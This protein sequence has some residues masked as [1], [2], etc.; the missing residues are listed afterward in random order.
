MLNPLLT[1]ARTHAS[2]MEEI[3]HDLHRNP[4]LGRQETATPAR[5][6]AELE[7]LGIEAVTMA[8]TGVMGIIRGGKPGKTVCFRADMDALPIQEK[9]ELSYASQVPGVMHA[10]GHDVHVAILLGA[11]KILMSRKEQLQGNVKLFFQPDEE[12]FGG[13][14]RM[15]LDGC[16][17]DPPVDAAFCIHVSNS[18]PAGSVAVRSGAVTA[19]CNTF[20]V[21]FRGKGCH[22]SSPHLGRDV[23][24]AACQA[25][26]ALQ[27]ISSRSVAPTDPVV[28]TVGA[29]HAGTAENILPEEATIKGT[30]RTMSAQTRQKVKEEFCRIVQAA[31]SAMDVEADIQIIDGYPA[32][33]NDAEMTDLMRGAA[34]KVIGKENVFEVSTSSMGADDFGYFSEK[35]PGCYFQVGTNN[36]EKGCVYPIHNPKFIADLDVLPAAAAIYA[37]IVLD[38][39][40]G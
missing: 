30:I 13:A 11:A 18:Y 20:A 2:M 27:T 39:L 38:Y 21:T 6:R 24:V 31:A 22:G 26:M 19:A 10:C 32:G 28:V 3:V 29:F 16:M 40:N 23:I 9:T 34:Q 14:E 5:I 36:P 17:E 1:E 33:R 12:G 37:Q 7:K 4:E 15:I 25:V 8:D 35:V